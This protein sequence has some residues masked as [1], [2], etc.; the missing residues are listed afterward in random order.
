M[1][2]YI[3]I[4]LI[5]KYIKDKKLSMSRFCKKCNIKIDTFYKIMLNK[6]VMINSLYKVANGME[7]KFNEMFFA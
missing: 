3:N 6:N 4:Q 5:E 1:K 7:I 2:K